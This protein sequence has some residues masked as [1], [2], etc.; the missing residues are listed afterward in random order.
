MPN[1]LLS[2]SLSR[3]LAH[4]HV[5]THNENQKKQRIVSLKQTEAKGN[6]K[7]GAV[8]GRPQGV[9]MYICTGVQQTQLPHR[10]KVGQG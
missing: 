1:I 9:Y 3:D 2:L 5:E 8:T 6:Q 4:S 7:Q 10:G